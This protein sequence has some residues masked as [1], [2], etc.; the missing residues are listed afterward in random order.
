[1]PFLAM[2]GFIF[3]QS[4]FSKAL[5]FRKDMAIGPA[6]VMWLE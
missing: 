4:V 2:C 6:R 3:S 1:M 5:L